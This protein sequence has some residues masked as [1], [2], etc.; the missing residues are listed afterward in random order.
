MFLTR[1]FAENDF[2]V[3]LVEALQGHDRVENSELILKNVIFLAF[4]KTDQNFQ[5]P[6][7]SSFWVDEVEDLLNKLLINLLLQNEGVILEGGHDDLVLVK[8]E[9]DLA[10]KGGEAVKN[11]QLVFVVVEREVG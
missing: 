2:F 6:G 11:V 10:E 9:L 5:K 8:I 4:N 7:L 3:F 1:T